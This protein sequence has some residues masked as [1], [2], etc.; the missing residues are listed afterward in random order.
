[1]A[2]F[3]SYNETPEMTPIEQIVYF[4]LISYLGW[5]KIKS[6]KQQSPIGIYRADF[7]VEVINY[8]TAMVDNIA[9]ECDGHDYHERTSSQAQHDKKRDRFFQDEGFKVYRFTGS[10]IWKSRG[11]CVL[12]ALGIE[13]M[14]DF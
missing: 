12:E 5:G 7:I 1:M 3:N 13:R 11:G 8:K 14:E 10:E 9:I 4:C 2:V 6:V